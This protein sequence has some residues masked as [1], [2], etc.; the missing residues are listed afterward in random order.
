M[1]IRSPEGG[2]PGLQ[3]PRGCREQAPK[4]SPSVNSWHLSREREHRG[5][6]DVGEPLQGWPIKAFSVSIP[7]VTM[8]RWCHWITRVPCSKTA[9]L[10]LVESAVVAVCPAQ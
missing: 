8:S 3:L 6:G 7:D 10:V 4:W 2:L 5:G 1:K 9:P